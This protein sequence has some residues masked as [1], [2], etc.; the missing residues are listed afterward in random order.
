MYPLTRHKLTEDESNYEPNHTDN[1]EK[2][3]QDIVKDLTERE[4][5]ILYSNALML[6]DELESLC[7]IIDGG[8]DK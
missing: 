2:N 8:F 3:R 1:T 5:D 4:K 7:D 6:T